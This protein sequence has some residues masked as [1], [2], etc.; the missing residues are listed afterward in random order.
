MTAQFKFMGEQRDP[1]IDNAEGRGFPRI[2][3]GT[4]RSMLD[5]VRSVLERLASGERIE[6]CGE[7]CEESPCLCCEARAL[8]ERIDG[9]ER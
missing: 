7:I 2:Y 1:D 9:G 5:D 4:K 6:A 3:D 8:V